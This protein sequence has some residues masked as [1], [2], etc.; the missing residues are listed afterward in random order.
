M[1]LLPI[2][3]TEEQSVCWNFR[4]SYNPSCSTKSRLNITTTH[5]IVPMLYWNMVSKPNYLWFLSQL[6]VLLVPSKAFWS[7][8]C[9]GRPSVSIKYA[10]DCEHHQYSTRKKC[11]T[12]KQTADV[13]RWFHARHT[14][15]RHQTNLKRTRHLFFL[16]IELSI[17]T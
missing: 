11:I 6:S 15:Q 17:Y 14:S 2:K 4:I 13:Q 12:T 10:R 8:L 9:W 16:F 5:F 1:P 7:T 3:L